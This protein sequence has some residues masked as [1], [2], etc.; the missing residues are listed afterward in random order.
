MRFKNF[1]EF[2]KK[3]KDIFEDVFNSYYKKGYFG[4]IDKNELKEHHKDWYAKFLSFIKEKNAPELALALSNKENKLSRE[5]F[6]QLTEL[7]VRYKTK[8][9]IIEIIKDYV[10]KTKNELRK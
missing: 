9:K 2:S 3:E 10:D 1:Y 4:D 5:W 7:N 8:E 6:T